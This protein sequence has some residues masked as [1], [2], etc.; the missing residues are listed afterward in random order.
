MKLLKLLI[1]HSISLLGFLLSWRKSS[2]QGEKR[3]AKIWLV[4]ISLLFNQLLGLLNFIC[5]V[6]LKYKNIQIQMHFFLLHIVMHSFYL[7][8]R[9][10]QYCHNS[11]I[12]EWSFTT[13]SC[14]SSRKDNSSARHLCEVFTSESWFL[15]FENLLYHSG[16]NLIAIISSKMIKWR[17]Y[18]VMR[19]PCL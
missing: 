11:N 16:W 18:W 10:Q 4:I 8:L 6:F 5:T 12:H 1:C 9:Y 13:P 17:H 7:L 3:S 19:T 14:L 2:F 15:C